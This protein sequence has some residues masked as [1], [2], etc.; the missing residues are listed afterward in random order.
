MLG[1]GGA[2]VRQGQPGPY[3]AET[4]RG[5]PVRSVVRCDP[6]AAA[7]HS[8]VLPP[9]ISRRT[10]RR[11]LP[12]HSEPAELVGVDDH[13]RGSDC[14]AYEGRSAPRPGRARTV[15]VVVPPLTW[16]AFVGLGV[17]I[18]A[19]VDRLALLSARSI[20]R[21]LGALADEA[22]AVARAGLPPRSPGSRRHE[23]DEDISVRT[24]SEDC[25]TVPGRSPSSPPALQQRGVTALQLA[26]EQTV[27]AASRETGAGAGA[28][29]ATCAMSCVAQ[30]ASSC[31]SVTGPNSGCTRSARGAAGRAQRL[32]LLEIG[33]AQLAELP[34]S[35]SA[36]QPR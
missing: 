28:I 33:A 14:T 23:S 13:A 18:L 2:R 17:L 7:P 19:V 15:S 22:D 16:R 11:R 20:T 12:A 36:V 3:R 9:D 21:P 25:R 4:V 27:L 32:E 1:S 24:S 10:G 29:C 34:T 31:A 35:A 5:R 30:Q 6:H 26:A 8:D